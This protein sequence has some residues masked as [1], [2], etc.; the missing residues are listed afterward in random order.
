M[1]TKALTPILL[2]DKIRKIGLIEKQGGNSVHAECILYQ[3]VNSLA[4][5]QQ[6]SYN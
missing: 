6:G 2:G 4:N 3:A 5:L 1:D